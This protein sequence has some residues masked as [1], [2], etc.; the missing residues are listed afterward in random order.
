MKEATATSTATSARTLHAIRTIAAST[1][2]WIAQCIIE[3][4]VWLDRAYVAD[5]CGADEREPDD[6]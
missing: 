6:D 4:A 3:A 1:C 2:M 5:V